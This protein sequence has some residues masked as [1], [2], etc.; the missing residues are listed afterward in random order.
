MS[1]AMSESA[2]SRNRVAADPSKNLPSVDCTP[3]CEGY[4]NDQSQSLLSALSSA[5]S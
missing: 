1:A 4:C 5:L 3:P 2:K